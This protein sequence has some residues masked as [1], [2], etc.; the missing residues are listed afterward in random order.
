MSE[1]VFRPQLPRRTRVA[2]YICLG[3]VFLGVIMVAVFP[4]IW[5]VGLLLA[6]L[7][8]G[9][10]Y[11]ILLVPREIV[12]GDAIIIRRRLLSDKRI[13]YH[14][15]TGFGL[16]RL[17][18]RNGSLGWHSYENADE[19][20]AI[21]DRLIEDGV[22]PIAKL[23]DRAYV[24]DMAMI[25]AGIY[26][27]ATIAIW[28][29]LLDLGLS[30]P[31]PFATGHVPLVIGMAILAISGVFFAWLRF[32]RLRKGAAAG[33]DVAP[34]DELGSSIQILD[35]HGSA[36]WSHCVFVFTLL[37]VTIPITIFEFGSSPTPVREVFWAASIGFHLWY[38]RI[39][40]QM[41]G[42]LF[43]ALRG[44][45]GG[46]AEPSVSADGILFPR[47]RWK[48]F[49]TWDDVAFVE[50]V[51]DVEENEPDEY[52]VRLLLR[53]GVELRMIDTANW[54]SFSKI[55]MLASG[56]LR[57]KVNLVGA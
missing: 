41:R 23:D 54:E 10:M 50:K 4:E 21:L 38:F 16:S 36:R 44:F 40:F 33:R 3:F 20:E 17:V 15:I 55:D 47:P 12:F 32:W 49:Y 28:A 1:S 19:L 14:D 46:Q 5:G 53:N 35:L 8:G 51:K 39:V 57:N 30:P 26:A 2:P 37:L 45:L 31:L 42:E 56:A 27:M 18:S 52:Y 6:S 22:I 34:A 11:L 13:E 9:L 48:E 7:G 25:D 29:L 24:T 43:A